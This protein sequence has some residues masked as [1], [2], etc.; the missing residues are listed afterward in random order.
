MIDKE[1]L[2]DAI[3]MFK[4]HGEASMTFIINCLCFSFPLSTA[5]FEIKLTQMS[6]NKHEVCIELEKTAQSD[7]CTTKFSQNV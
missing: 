2:N 3:V 1:G 5:L 6:L 4:L 7:S